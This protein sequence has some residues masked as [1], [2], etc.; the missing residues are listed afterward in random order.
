[1]EQSP[2]SEGYDSYLQSVKDGCRSVV[3]PEG[4]KADHESLVEFKEGAMEAACDIYATDT[5][6]PPDSMLDDEPLKIDE[7]T[8]LVVNEHIQESKHS[9][10]A[11]LLMFNESDNVKYFESDNE[12]F[13]WCRYNFCPGDR[14]E[15]IGVLTNTNYFLD[16]FL[17]TNIGNHFKRDHKDSL[18]IECVQSTMFDN[19]GYYKFNGEH[20]LFLSFDE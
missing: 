12:P 13:L 16:W 15:V 5:Y 4:I 7:F 3:I 1:M 20:V 10:R 8:E 19:Y 14:I 17:N 6:T 2:Y 11:G 18:I 9:C